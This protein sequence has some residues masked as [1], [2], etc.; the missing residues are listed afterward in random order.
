MKIYIIRHAEKESGNFYNPRLRHQ[1]EPIS[2][3]GRQSAERLGTFFAERPIDAIFVSGY[4]RTGETIQSVAR[5]LELIPIVDERLNEIDNGLLEGLGDME[6]QKQYPDVWRAFME[7]SAD[8]RFP[9]GETG[10]EVR[11]RI[12]SFLEEKRDQYPNGIIAVA[13]DGLIRTL[14]CHVLGLPV[15]R[16]WDFQ[17]DVCGIVELSSRPDFGHWTLSRFNHA[18]L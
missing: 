9:E 13:H 16:R 6:I 12:A 2:E 4:R 5:R 10:E 1:D 7:R 18:C 14:M 8:F 3:K 11:G 17:I 15:Y